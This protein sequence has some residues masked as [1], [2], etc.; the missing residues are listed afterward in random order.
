MAE[1][2]VLDSFFEVDYMKR[3]ALETV[4]AW[5]DEIRRLM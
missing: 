4:I 3:L 2:K 1:E 5:I